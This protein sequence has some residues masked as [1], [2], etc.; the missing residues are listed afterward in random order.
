[1]GLAPSLHIAADCREIPGTRPGMTSIGGT[2]PGMTG[3][4]RTPLQTL[5]A[6]LLQAGGAQAGEAVIVDRGL[7]GEKFLDGQL[8][9]VAG[10]LETEK[11]A[12]YRRHD[13]RLAAD[14]PSSRI[15][16]RKVGN[17]Q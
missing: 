12:P 16:G 7:P 17:G 10:F 14:H 2:S 13:L 6:V 3:V 11:S 15:A 4:A 5:M 8:V 1:K 9:A